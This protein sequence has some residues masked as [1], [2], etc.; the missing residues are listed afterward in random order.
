MNRRVES[1]HALAYA[2]WMA[3]DLDVPL[4]FYGGLTCAYPYVSDACKPLSSKECP[5]RGA[6]CGTRPRSKS[7]RVK[8][9][10][11]PALAHRGISGRVI[12]GRKLAF[13][14]ARFFGSRPSFHN[15][16]AWA[17]ATMKKHLRDK[18]PYVYAREQFFGGQ[19]HDP[20]WNAT[21]KQM[22]IESGSLWV[23][24]DV[25]GQENYR[26]VSPLT[27][28]HSIL[29]SKFMTVMRSPATLVP[30]PSFSGVSA[31]TTARGRS[32]RWVQFDACLTT[33]RRRKTEVD[34]SIH[35]IERFERT[36]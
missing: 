26:V 1:N 19:T 28:T 4:T 2:A 15:P 35:E 29:W 6:R 17:L 25:L 18:R 10:R 9:P 12:V 8:C 21:Q 34:A 36:L 11:Y 7:L 5:K 3:N 16:R 13:H 23:P 24:P 20:L 27:R 32:G 31:C 22:L 14:F 30:M 33:G